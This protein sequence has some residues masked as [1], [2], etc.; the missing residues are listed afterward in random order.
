[1]APLEAENLTYGEPD[2]SDYV[3][4][5]NV[6]DK[7]ATPT[8]S[9]SS[10]ERGHHTLSAISK[11]PASSG[12]LNNNDGMRKTRAQGKHD[13]ANAGQATKTAELEGRFDDAAISTIEAWTARKSYSDIHRFSAGEKLDMVRHLTEICLRCRE[14]D[15]VHFIIGLDELEQDARYLD[16]EGWGRYCVNIGLLY[17]RWSPQQNLGKSKHYLE[18]GLT[19]LVRVGSSNWHILH[20]ACQTLIDLY[21]LNEDRGGAQ[22]FMATVRKDMS[23]DL[24][25][26]VTVGE[27]AAVN[28]WCE[29]Q[30]FSMCQYYS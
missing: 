21:D 11:L 2:V 28:K 29:N 24:A 6:N 23:S 15:K 3:Q 5:G 13:Y 12:Q 10:I 18:L 26:R 22:S 8:S 19:T 30:G 16:A 14:L 9:S 1:M 20:G 25:D 17:L 7:Q 4:V 27:I